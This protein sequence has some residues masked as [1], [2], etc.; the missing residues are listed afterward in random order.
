[1]PKVIQ[2]RDVPDDVHAELTRLAEAAGLSLSK[3]GLRELEYVSRVGRNATIFTQLRQLPPT[4]ISDEQIAEDIRAER[5]RA[6]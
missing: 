1:M 3:F 4:G 6:G 2:I 5:E